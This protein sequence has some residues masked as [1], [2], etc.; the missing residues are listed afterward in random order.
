MS[1]KDAGQF[2][3]QITLSDDGTIPKFD[4]IVSFMVGIEY[5]PLDPLEKYDLLG[6]I[7]FEK[8]LKD[9]PGEQSGDTAKSSE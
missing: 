4:S 3:I 9:Q 2:E 7:E 8:L 5:T 1:I 6:L